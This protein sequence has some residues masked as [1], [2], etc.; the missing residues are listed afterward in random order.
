M[1]GT[2]AKWRE[3][4]GGAVHVLTFEEHTGSSKIAAF[5]LVRG[6]RVVCVW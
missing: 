4:V 2:Q 6:V 5:D 3:E 1:L